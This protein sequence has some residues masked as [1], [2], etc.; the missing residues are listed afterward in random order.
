ME[1][2]VS[3]SQFACMAC[4]LI[5]S[6]LISSHIISPDEAYGAGENKEAIEVAHV[7]DVIDFLL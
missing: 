5:S 1:G 3:A 6:H 4:H 2:T 7:D